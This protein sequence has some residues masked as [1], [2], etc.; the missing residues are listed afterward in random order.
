MPKKKNLM[1]EREREREKLFNTVNHNWREKDKV[2]YG[3][4]V[5]KS[6]NLLR[7]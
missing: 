1:S 2:K 3:L 6:F 5:F 7:C 4:G